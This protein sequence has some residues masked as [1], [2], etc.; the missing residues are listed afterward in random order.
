MAWHYLLSLS[1]K[2]PFCAYVESP[3]SQKR[4]GQRSLNPLHIQ[5]FVPSLS[6]P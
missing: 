5:G 3:L 4:E 2:K 1:H 6:L